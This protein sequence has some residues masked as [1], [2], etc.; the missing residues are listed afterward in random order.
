MNLPL[1]RYT[2][3]SHLV[4]GLIFLAIMIMYLSI[5]ISMYDPENI[6]NM[7]DLVEMLPEELVAAMGFDAAVTDLTSFIASYY[8]NFL[9]FLF[10][11]V[12][13][14]IV[15]N[16]LVAGHV[17]RGSMAYLLS[18]PSSRVK[19]ITTQAVFLMASVA[20]LIILIALAGLAFSSAMFPGELN[21]G[22]FLV[23]NA[24][25]VFLLQ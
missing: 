8:Y 24:G 10:S 6:Q 17:D 5:I 19:I 18:T 23:L 2:A 16:R 7:A 20:L 4:V 14:I 3:R 11:L 1:F 25:A 21:I 15:G 22:D 13:C 12:Y 9:I